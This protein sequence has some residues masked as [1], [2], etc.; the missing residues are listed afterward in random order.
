MLEGS[1]PENGPGAVGLFNFIRRIGFPSTAE[2]MSVFI[3]VIFL[4]MVLGLPAYGV[5][6]QLL[7]VDSL[8]VIILPTILGQIVTTSVV[9][10]DEVFTF[11]RLMGLEVL[12]W[13]LAPVI[14]PASAGV[15]SFGIGPSW[16]TSI[17]FAVTI[18]LP[19]RMLSFVSLTDRSIPRRILASLV[20][21]VFVSAALIFSG[22]PEALGI[23]TAL[24]LVSLVSIVGIVRLL[25]SI[26]REGRTR[27]GAPPMQ[28]FRAFLLHWLNRDPE[29]LEENLTALGLDDDIRTN[30]IAFFGK[31][32]KRKGALIVS[33]FHPGPY[34]DLGSG[35]LPSQLKKHVE[36]RLGG[37][38]HVPH[39]I[40]SH[41]SNIISRKDVA[42]FLDHVASNYPVKPTTATASAMV[43]GVKEVAKASGQ[44]FDHTAL[45]TL[46]L[47]PENME[48]LPRQLGEI[49]RATAQSFGFGVVVVD[50]H[51]SMSDETTVT[52]AQAEELA[53]AAKDAVR[54]LNHAEQSGFKAGFS[55]DSLQDFRLED[56]I[57]PGGVSVLVVSN[58]GQ[59]VAYVTIDGNNMEPGFRESVLSSLGELG[60]VDGE[61][62][63]TDTHLVTGLVRSPLGYYPVGAHVDRDRLVARIK[64][65]V[66]RAV[67]DLEDSSLGFS[68]SSI[69][70]RVLG[71]ETFQN[72]TSYI[73]Q[74]GSR[75]RSLFYVLELVCVTIA[76]LVLAVM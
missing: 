4:S 1:P 40:S 11:R 36:Q 14:L 52:A 6:L 7:V 12:S 75:V 44:L 21:P 23:I 57:G 15:Q 66:K 3:T 50:A 27:V 41:Q 37:I 46:T 9:L 69:R 56:G 76:I 17:V 63:T 53:L 61:V 35:G 59:R 42:R 2:L 51:N 64:N 18:S 70:L 71:K 19:I 31:N 47:S 26:D 43:R 24:L 28:L 60:I 39:G 22:A 20:V 45:I 32:G 65:T 68:N 13:A 48:D 34:R 10:R 38:V 62:M 30:V 55:D 73:R 72:L 58:Q 33:S 29:S 54:S 8:V 74:V 25:R 16:Q 67:D 5:N 49:I